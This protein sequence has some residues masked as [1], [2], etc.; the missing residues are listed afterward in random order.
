VQ[1]S[2]RYSSAR[3][4]VKINRPGAAVA[5][6]VAVST[7]ATA[8]A[9]VVLPD[10]APSLDVVV[11]FAEVCEVNASS[12]TRNYDSTAAV[13]PANVTL[14]AS[15]VAMS[16]TTSVATTPSVGRTPQGSAASVTTCSGRSAW[17]SDSRT[18]APMSSI[19]GTIRR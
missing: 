1:N 14:V 6:A 13:Q 11:A 9:A 7:A 19:E 15:P 8:T 18:T 12:S 4:S 16:I 17:S 5:C 2:S 10:R 3:S